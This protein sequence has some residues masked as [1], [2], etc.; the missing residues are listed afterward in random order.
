MA[1]VGA[2]GTV[3]ALKEGTTV[4][5]AKC[6]EKSAEC[7]VTVKAE[8][9]A[10]ASVTVDQSTLSLAVGQ[11]AALKATVLPENAADKAVT[12]SS[13]ASNIVEVASDG[14]VTAKAVGTATVTVTTVNRLKATCT[15]TVTEPTGEQN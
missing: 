11:T 14:T 2:D 5:T 3:T 10:P 1:T 15:I 6:G 4:I 7:T 9:V 13:D 12:W 8:T